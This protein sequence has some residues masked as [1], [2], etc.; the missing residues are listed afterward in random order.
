MIK[1]K[2]GKFVIIN[3]SCTSDCYIHK[4]RNNVRTIGLLKQ[5]ES[6]SEAARAHYLSKLL[7]ILQELIR[8][9]KLFCF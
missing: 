3:A 5:F 9:E 8:L 6:K 4:M 1:N 7:V 2:L